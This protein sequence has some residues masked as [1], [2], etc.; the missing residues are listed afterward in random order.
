MIDITYKNKKTTAIVC[1]NCTII[2]NRYYKPGKNYDRVFKKI[3]NGLKD[4]YI[5]NPA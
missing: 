4:R 3:Y 1:G 2:G 5:Q